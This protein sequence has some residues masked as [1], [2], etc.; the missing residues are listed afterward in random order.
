MKVGT[1][2]KIKFWSLRASIGDSGGVTF[3]ND[4]RVVKNCRLVMGEYGLKWQLIKN[5]EYDYSYC[6]ETDQECLN[7]YDYTHVEI[8]KLPMEK[9]RNNGFR[10]ISNR[11]FE[12]K[13]I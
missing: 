5:R 11:T 7:E 2:R 10:G 3:D 9:Y 6:N 1:I 13:L 8:L 4:E 12:S